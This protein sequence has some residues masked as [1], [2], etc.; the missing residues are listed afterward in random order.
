[1]VQKANLTWKSADLYLGLALFNFLLC[2][3]L[4]IF[5]SPE[6]T[7]FEN[8]KS[9]KKYEN[10]N[11]K[12]AQ[13]E[14]FKLQTEILKAYRTGNTKEVLK[15]QHALTRSFAARALAVRKVTTN[16]GKNTPGIDKIVLKTNEQKFKAITNVKNLS[17]YKAQ[18]VRRIYIPK[19]NGKLRPLGIP[20]IMDRIVQTL[21]YFAIDPIAEETACKRSYGF[22]LHR[23][24]HDNAQ[25]LKLVLGNYTSTRR[26]VL[27][28][29]IQG[30]FSSVNHNWLL[31]NVIIDKRILKEILKAGH[32]EDFILHDTSEGFPQGSAISP[33]LANLVLNGLEEHLGKEFLT[34]RYADDFIVAGKS[35]EELRNLA[36]PKINSF[37][38][39]R[40][41]SLDP[42]KTRIFSIEEG[43][44]F[45]GF[46]FREYP[47]K[48]RA[49]GTKKGIFL[50]KP[51]PIKVKTFVR[52]LKAIVKKY[53]NRPFYDLVAKL[54]QK[55]RGW[56]EHY[57]KVSSQQTFS[58]INFHVWTALWFMIKKKHRRRSKTWLYKTYFVK[59]KE[60]KWV[61]VGKKG[62]NSLTLFQIPYVTIKYHW[63]CKDANAYDPAFIEYFYKRNVS[64]SKNVLLSGGTKS[65]IAKIQNGYCP[66]C[67]MSLF[68]GEDLEIHHIL[69][70]REGND[71]SLKNLK[72][73]HKLCHKQI[74]YS[75]D[76]SLKAVWL[77]KG[78]L[79]PEK[80]K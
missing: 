63:L 9:L 33:S 6:R 28:A 55:L 66:V 74:E 14:L 49:K 60:N 51:S 77:K 46:Y 29:D 34:T 44:E 40:G 67:E 43:F 59:V 10:I 24:V 72:L 68:N 71:H 61:F 38:I 11:W 23:G 20:T 27:K 22:R 64:E 19:A 62:T 3:M 13:L 58:T 35:P 69:P 5:F 32:V 4:L 15:A 73:L 30:F 42:D 70:R 39:E 31:D 41:L 21:F 53:K 37:L 2:I 80:K 78:I 75:K 36:L 25:Y 8:M 48:N 54:N 1:M 50:I 16:K 47:D 26:Y 56:A 76:S 12:Q 79:L 17:S 57:K 7:V 45:L 65:A 18:P 52:E